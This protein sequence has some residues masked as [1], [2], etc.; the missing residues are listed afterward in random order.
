MFKP[1]TD[2]PVDSYNQDG[3]I[4][5]HNHDFIREKEFCSAYQRGVKAVGKDY[6][7]HWRVHIGL[8][9]A[10]TA[11]KKP[12]DF[13]ECGV[14]AGFLSSSIMHDLDWDSRGKIFF[15][16]DTFAGID[17]KHVTEEELREGISQKN[18]EMIESGFYLTSSESVKINFSEW[19][20]IKIIE[21]VIP[22]TLGEITSSQISFLH[23]DLNC[24]PPEIAAIEFL[25][26]RLVSGAIV[27]LDDYAYS[28]YHHQ[29]TSM[30]NFARSRGVSIASLP[31]GQ[32]LLIKE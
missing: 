30:D 21:G 6:Q 9:A 12:G 25:W 31:T 19:R 11:I 27:L 16:L 22:D 23:I 4:S 28:G 8:W 3:L 32:G 2:F 15:L 1:H 20:N 18:T 14:N 26:S 7:W 29:K 5:M 10:R 13:V 17:L 24:A